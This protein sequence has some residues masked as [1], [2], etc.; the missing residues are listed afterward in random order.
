MNLF[1]ANHFYRKYQFITPCSSETPFI[2]NIKGEIIEFSDP[3]LLIEFL[4]TSDDA[5]Y[6]WSDSEELAILADLYQMRIKIITTNRKI[7][8]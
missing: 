7:Q 3:E 5:Q 4:K 1:W 6:M 8:Q 2:R